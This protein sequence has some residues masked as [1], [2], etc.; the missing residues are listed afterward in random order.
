VDWVDEAMSRINTAFLWKK[1]A[2]IG[3]HR[4]NY[5][6]TIDPENRSRNLE[7]LGQLLKRIVKQWPDVE[8]ISSADLA[9][10]IWEH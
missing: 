9:E 4:L 2:V 10:I 6:G 1:P 5:I 3:S 7:T 8:F